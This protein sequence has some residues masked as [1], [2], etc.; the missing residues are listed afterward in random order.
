M[1]GRGLIL[2]VAMLFAACGG[3]DSRLSLETADRPLGNVGSFG[4]PPG[5]S[6]SGILEG[7]PARVQPWEIDASRELVLTHLSVVED[8][9]STA[10]GGAWSFDRLMRDMEGE[11]DASQ[12]VMRWLAT[13]RT[14]QLINGYPV[15]ARPPIDTEVI[16]PWR[17][18]SG[19]PATDETCKLDLR[20]SPFRLSAIVYRPDLRLP[21]LKGGE[22]RFVF[23]VADARGQAMSFTVILEYLLP[24]SDGAQDVLSWADQFHK[25][26]KRDFGEPFNQALQ[27]ITDQFAKRGVT[28]GR[29]NGSALAQLR[30]NELSQHPGI[31]KR[32]WELREFQIGWD[33]WIH[34][35]T[36]KQTPDLSL[37]GTPALAD[38]LVRNQ[39]SIRA[40]VHRIPDAML[41]GSAPVPGG[42]GWTFG[43]EAGVSEEVRHLFAL[44]TC[45][46]CHR[47]E[48]R[49]PA[50]GTLTLFTHIAARDA[51]T[52]AATSGFL[53]ND[54][55]VFRRNDF[56]GLLSLTPADL[57]AKEGRRPK[58]A[59]VH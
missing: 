51:G 3:D 4:G 26:G 23:G 5:N 43:A 45:N 49:D 55:A 15:P 20:R 1:H 18:R 58:R 8:P 50:T 52:P 16:G 42:S 54:I 27:R 59:R 12:F 56:A 11:K 48:T 40:G 30:T 28:P 46:G 35:V 22:G 21:E 9:A 37:N 17:M 2:T 24:A 29:P 53:R 14:S 47:W 33:G 19:W 31:P 13:W 44:T 36:V 25:L 57:Q 7:T 41:G 6:D 34:E 39:E 38:F 32:L 10:P